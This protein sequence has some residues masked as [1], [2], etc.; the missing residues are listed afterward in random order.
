MARQSGQA[1][2]QNTESLSGRHQPV[3]HLLGVD[4]EFLYFRDRMQVGGIIEN[5]VA[6]E[7]T[8][9]IAMATTTARLNHYRTSS[10]QK[11]N[12]VPE[13]QRSKPSIEV[14]STSKVIA[15]GFRNL[16]TLKFKIGARFEC[17]FVAYPGNDFVQLGN[18]LYALPLASL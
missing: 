13:S 17:G 5:F 16:K 18:R 9:Q 6:V 7:L 14:K 12:F 15:R 4:Q 10:Q 1:T 2:H 3:N 11:V 8:R